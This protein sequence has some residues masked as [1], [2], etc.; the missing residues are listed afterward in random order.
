MKTR[1]VWRA[2][3]APDVPTLLLDTHVWVWYVD[4]AEDRLSTTA[5]GVIRHALRREGLLVSDISVWELGTKAAKGKITLS[6]N[7]HS[8]IERAARRPGFSFLPLDREILLAST[9][10]Q[11]GVHGDPADRMLVAS[12]SLAGVPLATADPKIIDYAAQQGGFSVFDVR[13]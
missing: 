9:Q 11:G 7:L 3:D 5:T 4:G 6:P 10:L 12:A 1:S 2:D 8:W 13:P